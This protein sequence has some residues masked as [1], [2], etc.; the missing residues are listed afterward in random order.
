[1]LLAVSPMDDAELSSSE[2]YSVAIKSN[3]DFK[4]NDFSIIFN[5]DIELNLTG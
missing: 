1:M 4:L 5:V 3:E 2:S